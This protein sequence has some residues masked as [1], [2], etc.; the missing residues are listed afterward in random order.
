VE[1]AHPRIALLDIEGTTSSISFVHDVLFPYAAREADGYL[2]AN[3]RSP[4][5]MEVLSQMARDAGAADF[6][7][8]CPAPWPSEQA[9]A[10]VLSQIR[11]WMARDTKLTGLKKL[12]GMIWADGYASGA[13]HSH[14]FA[15]VPAKLREWKSSGVLVC[16]YSSGSVAAQKLFFAHAEGGDLTPLLSGFFDTETGPKQSPGSYRAIAAKLG[17]A[18]SEILF[19]SDVVGE[20]DAAAEAG[21]GTTLVIRPGNK[22]VGP[23]PHPSIGSFE[24]IR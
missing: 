7:A 13:F 5:L 12:Q 19:L 23:H 14:V 15:D 22:P 8:W 11:E 24:E 6:A 9:H 20:L 16:I 18:T 17:V 2:R 21:C 3:A 4:A 1:G 10:R